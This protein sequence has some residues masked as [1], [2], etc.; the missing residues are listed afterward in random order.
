[1]SDVREV[2]ATIRRIALALLAGAAL[3]L[4]FD[5]VLQTVL[6][7][8]RVGGSS[9]IWSS[10][11]ATTVRRTV[12]LFAALLLWLIAPSVASALDS[13][14]GMPELRGTRAQATRAVGVGIIAIP[15]LWVVAVSAVR[16]VTITLAGNWTSEGRI[17]VEPQFYADII[18]G[19][20][21]WVLS[22]LALVAVARHL[23]LAS[24]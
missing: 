22:G 2:T 11:A 24:R 19:Y 1:V 7:F 9:A 8:V 21:P 3:A 16:C 12:W 10:I 20:G 14:G 15:L 4:V 18:A 13:D 17:F 5:V 6:G 23:Q